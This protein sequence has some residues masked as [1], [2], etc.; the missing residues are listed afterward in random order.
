MLRHARPA[1]VVFQLLTRAGASAAVVAALATTAGA[2]VTPPAASDASRRAAERVRALRA[3][4]DALLSQERSVLGELRRLEAERDARA[5]QVRSLVAEVAGVERDL[6]AT[7]SHLA[8][9][10]RNYAE[11][12]PRL[13][14][15][16]V[17]LYKLGA[18]GYARLLAGVDD[19][20]DVGRAYRTITALAAL[21]RER[22]RAHASTL[23]S[24]RRARD[25]L[26][27]RRQSLARLRRDQD[28]ARARAEAAVRSHAALVASIDA[29]RDLNAQL[30][31]E[32]MAAQET[33]ERQIAATG[34]SD[35][36]LPLAPF[37]GALD[38]PVA[39][40][41][42]RQFV[43]PGR[44]AGGAVRRGIDIASAASAPVAAVH[45]GTV[46]FAGA[47]CRLRQPRHRRP[48]GQSVDGLRLP[49]PGR[50]RQ[51]RARDP[52]PG[53]RR[54]GHG[55]VGHRRAVPRTADRRLAPSIPYNG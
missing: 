53:A 36:V 16:L 40:R 17:E 20:R 34:S 26:A 27:A 19:L 14:Q 29:R 22:A 32:L 37:K 21:D 54:Y 46:A 35:T 55:P 18:P 25:E 38:W 7:E 33:L 9:L 6:A 13:R 41:V 44:L 30:T 42:V 15:R 52:R 2:Q 1:T 50:G 49:R 51:G 23:S 5:A 10:E 24:L 31:G 4:A 39:G 8:A 28:E 47:A 3:E 45:D 43:A 12:A 48:R 11:Q